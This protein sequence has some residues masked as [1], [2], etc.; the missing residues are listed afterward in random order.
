MS[1]L[2]LSTAARLLVALL[3]LFSIFVMLRGHDEPGGGF[4]GG[5]IAATAFALYVMAEGAGA[6]RAVLR[7]DPRKVAGLG[8]AC[9]LAA[10]LIGLPA[11]EPFLRG[12]WVV[13]P[14]GKIGTPL[15]F[16]VGVYLVVL[17]GIVALVLALEE[18]R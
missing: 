7:I 15:L 12:L 9:A 13:L 8:L 10:G 4:I 16:D 6:V 18:Q 2:I 1:S 11:G 5:L 3:L 14:S 17:G